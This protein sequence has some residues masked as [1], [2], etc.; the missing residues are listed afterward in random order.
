MAWEAV[1][2][3]LEDM[4]SLDGFK[5]YF[6]STWMRGQFS[7]PLWNYY[8][9]DGPRTN[10]RLEGWHNRLKRIVKKPHPNI[11]ELI[12]VFKREQ[13]ASEVTLQQL[14]TGANPPP[15]K[16]KYRQLEQ[17]VERIKEKMSAGQMSISKYLDAILD[18]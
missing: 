5:T 13:A 12:D 16:K 11:Y 7:L 2:Q 8:S 17:R 4:D 1:A 18:I 10:N 15:W 9:Y 14:E 6:D 3:E